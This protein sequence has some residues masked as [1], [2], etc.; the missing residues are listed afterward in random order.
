[1]SSTGVIRYP[2]ILPREQKR[3]SVFPRGGSVCSQNVAD[4]ELAEHLVGR[5]AIRIC[6]HHAP[7]TLRPSIGSLSVRG[8]GLDIAQW[9]VLQWERCLRW[10]QDLAGLETEVEECQE[11]NFP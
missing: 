8:F 7:R 2:A 1:M 3:D 11:R 9:K 6:L 4:F 10:T 5:Q